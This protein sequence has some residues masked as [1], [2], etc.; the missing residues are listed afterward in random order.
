M[1]SVSKLS[2]EW[3]STAR[4]FQCVDRDRAVMEFACLVASALMRDMV[5]EKFEK[6]NFPSFC[7]WDNGLSDHCQQ[8]SYIALLTH[9]G[10]LSVSYHH[11]HHHL[12]CLY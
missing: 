7:V 6:S 1:L 12:Y 3:S 9:L 10:C 8:H 4:R 11:C 2:F 5:L